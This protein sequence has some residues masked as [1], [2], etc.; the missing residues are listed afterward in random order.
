[1]GESFGAAVARDF[2]AFPEQDKSVAI[3]VDF[4]IL[5]VSGVDDCFCKVWPGLRRGLP[6]ILNTF[7]RD[8][9]P[10]RDFSPFA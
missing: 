10:L 4:C 3:L 7:T 1:M 8:S 5:Q 9:K 6:T 2:P